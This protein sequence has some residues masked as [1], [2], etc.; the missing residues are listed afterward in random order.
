MRAV[1]ATNFSSEEFSMVSDYLTIIRQAELELDK[2]GKASDK[3]ITAIYTAVVGLSAYLVNSMARTLNIGSRTS[4][5]K[6]VGVNFSA[7]AAGLSKNFYRIFV[8][9]TD[10]YLFN[11]M[12][13]RLGNLAKS[14]S[15]KITG[16]LD[17]S[18]YDIRGIINQ[19]KAIIASNVYIDKLKQAVSSRKS[20]LV[21]KVS[22]PI[23]GL[24]AK[25]T[26]EAAKLTGRV[27]YST[28][29]AITVSNPFTLLLDIIFFAAIQ[30]GFAKVEENNLMRQPLLYFPLIRHGK[31]YVGGMA[32]VVR[33]TWAN[34]Q[35]KET[36]KTIKEIQKASSILVGN[37]DVT[38]LSGDR[39]FYISLLNGVAGD[40][41][42]V[43]PPLYQTDSDGNKI[44]VNENKVTTEKQSSALSSKK[45]QSYL[46][47]EEI[48]KQQLIQ[49]MNDNSIS[50]YTGGL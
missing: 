28:V 4:L 2:I 50:G 23:L 44:V 11:K 9:Q 10:K 30:Y 21:W 18:K 19:P 14:Q 16:W 33:N 45:L 37:N 5:L 40:S 15:G 39:P 3:E 13:D 25:A 49:K 46:Q 41:N 12:K 32:G 31:P 24:S 26:I 38:N 8:N 20:G 1:V 35:L 7:G 47:D 42:K 17:K 34:S 36:Q 6:F 22:K 29:L 43:S 48:L 27:L